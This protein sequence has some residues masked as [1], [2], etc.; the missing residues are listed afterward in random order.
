VRI[1]GQPLTL[2]A[3]RQ[4]LRDAILNLALNS[5]TALPRGGSLTLAAERSPG[6]AVLSVAD[7]GPG[8]HPDMLSRLGKPFATNT[9][10]GTGLGVLLAQS[11]ARQHGGTLRFESEAGGGTT[12]FLELPLGAGPAPAGQ[13]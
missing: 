12:A 1:L 4:R 8:I 13:R 3:D 9:A 7:D 10:G 6:R 11:V 5:V 2:W